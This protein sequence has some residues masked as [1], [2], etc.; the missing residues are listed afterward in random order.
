MSEFLHKLHFRNPINEEVFSIYIDASI[1]S[2]E[3]KEILCAKLE[4]NMDPNTMELLH[5]TLNNYIIPVKTVISIAGKF[6]EN[7][8]LTPIFKVSPTSPNFFTH[9]I[10][11]I[12]KFF[13]KI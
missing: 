2:V 5:F 3:L 13:N 4:P 7:E 6:K 1:T 11:M 8:I 12:A 9:S 10:L